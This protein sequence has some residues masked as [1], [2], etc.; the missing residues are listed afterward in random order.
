MVDSQCCFLLTLFSY[1]EGLAHRALIKMATAPVNNLASGV[2]TN[3]TG[4][5]KEACEDA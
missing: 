2:F 5:S 3:A 4:F 1:G